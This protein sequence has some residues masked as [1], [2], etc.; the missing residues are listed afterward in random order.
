MTDLYLLEDG[1]GYYLYENNDRAKID[2]LITNNNETVGVTETTLLVKFKNILNTVGLTE[3]VNHAIGFAKTATQSIVGVTESLNTKT[4]NQNILLEDNSNDALLLEDGSGL[5]LLDFLIAT[6]NDTVGI[7]EAS[8]KAQGLLEIINDTVGFTDALNY[9]TGFFKVVTEAIVGVEYVLNKILTEINLY[10]L[11]DGSG[12]YELEDGAG[13]YELDQL[14]LL[15]YASSTLGLTEVS[16]KFA[17]AFK[18]IADTVNLNETIV[19]ARVMFRNITT[20]I[21]GLVEADNHALNLVR[22]VALSTVGL[23]EALNKALSITTAATTVGL[24]EAVNSGRGRLQNIAETVGLT[25][26]RNTISGIV[27]YISD[28]IGLTDVVNRIRSVF[29]SNN[30]GDWIA[31]DAIDMGNFIAMDAKDIGNMTVIDSYNSGDFKIID[32]N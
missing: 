32:D 7:T 23:T 31:T 28:T 16:N 19:R 30:T 29:I 27:K 10:Q 24:T 6:S 21:V 11:E 15:K 4:R 25:E 9:V 3:A 20:S 8:N 14:L 12:R 22:T 1:S 17:G 18:N 26:A 5:Y 2:Q 13:N